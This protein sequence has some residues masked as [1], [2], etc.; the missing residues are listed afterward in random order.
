MNA[1][2]Q[3]YRKNGT[4]WQPKYIVSLDA[5]K[6]IAC[7]K[8]FKGCPAGVME[9][10]SEEDDEENEIMF[11]QLVKDG[12]CIGCQSCAMVCPKGCFTHME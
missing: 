12:D 11:M 9:L 1:T 4:Q 10:S 2:M 8:C 5:K 3:G 6:C 7:G